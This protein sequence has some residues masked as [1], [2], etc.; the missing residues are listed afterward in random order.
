MERH[1]QTV[2]QVIATAAV[3]GLATFAW[4]ANRT[5][6]QLDS[7]LDAIGADLGRMSRSVEQLAHTAETK[8]NHDRDVQAL[9]R[10]LAD[11]EERIRHVERNPGGRQ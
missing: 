2:L 1:V 5:I 4:E 10:R 11:F 9:D 3:L 8:A 7:R 6:G